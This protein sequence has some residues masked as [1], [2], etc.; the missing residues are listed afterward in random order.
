MFRRFCRYF[1]IK[2]VKKNL[3]FQK[4]FW[5]DIYCKYEINILKVMSQRKQDYHFIRND[6]KMPQIAELDESFIDQIR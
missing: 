6:G 1:K 5:N 2:F 3:C 4:N